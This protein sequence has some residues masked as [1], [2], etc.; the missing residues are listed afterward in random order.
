M[1][2][3]TFGTFF[4]TIFFGV[5]ALLPF[6]LFL[7]GDFSQMISSFGFTASIF[8]SFAYALLVWLTFAQ[9]VFDQYVNPKTRRVTQNKEDKTI[10]NQAGTPQMTGD[11]S[12]SMFE[13]QRAIIAE[14][15]SRLMYHPIQPIDDGVEVY[16]LPEDFTREDLKKLKENRAELASMA[17]QYADEHKSDARYV[18]YIKRF[19]ARERSLQEQ[20][21]K[22]DKKNKKKKK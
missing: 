21:Q 7:L 10:Y 2:M 14:G 13:Y 9:W 15:K 12:A 6:G 5:V 17:E 1:K 16:E 4:Q 11:D 20:E 18:E 22:V 8:F 3:L 19:E